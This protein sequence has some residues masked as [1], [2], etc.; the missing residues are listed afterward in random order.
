MSGL[1]SHLSFCQGARFH[2]HLKVYACFRP[3]AQIFNLLRVWQAGSPRF[4]SA[5]SG[6][7]LY[8]IFNF[9]V[10]HERG[11]AK[12]I[13]EPLTKDLDVEQTLEADLEARAKCAVVA[14]R[15]VRGGAGTLL[16]RE[17]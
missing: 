9:R 7:V 3:V 2:S 11:H 6:H 15:A 16:R 4:H 8:Y 12:L 17:E 5:R 14:R 13:T 1:E 10:G